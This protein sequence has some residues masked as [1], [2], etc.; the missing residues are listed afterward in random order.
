MSCIIRCITDDIFICIRECVRVTYWSLCRGWRK[1]RTSVVLLYYVSD[2]ICIFVFFFGPPI[3]PFKAA[4][5]LRWPCPRTSSCI[6]LPDRTSPSSRSIPAACFSPGIWSPSSLSPFG[7]RCTLRTR[8]PVPPLRLLQT[9]IK[10]YL[11]NSR[12]KSRMLLYKYS[13]MDKYIV[14]FIFDKSGDYLI[15]VCRERRSYSTFP[16]FTYTLDF[17]ILV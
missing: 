9:E 5:L 7:F 14:F 11:F 13:F 1:D 15:R 17:T 2:A 3:M 6:S 16:N 10:S 12:I 8:C 4:R